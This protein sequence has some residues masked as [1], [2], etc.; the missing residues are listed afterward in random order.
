MQY[1][2]IPTEEQLARVRERM[3][4]G[5]LALS[6]RIEGG[7]GCTIDVVIADGSRLVLRRYGPWYAERGED[8]AAREMKALELLQRSN[9]PAP[10]PIWMDTDDFFDEQAIITSF[11]DGEPDLTPAH[12]FEWAEQLATTLARVHSVTLDEEDVAYFPAGA[13]E[14]ERKISENPEL[15]LEHPLGEDLLRRRV[16]LGGRRVDTDQVFS[17]TDYWPGNTM[18]RGGDLIA[19]IDWEAPATG[20]REMDVA[21]CSIDIRYLGMEKVADRFISAYKEITG[22]HLPNLTHWEAIALC[23]PMPDIGMWA[24]AWASMG[25]RVTEDEARSSHTRVIESFLSRTG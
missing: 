25:R 18:W 4:C 24:P 12:P 2:P 22:A 10:A 3:G 9:I 15:V 7:L 6:H 1:A 17:H 14:D 23:R 21:Y 20:D 8:A 5:R 11:I 13:G 19:V 16:V